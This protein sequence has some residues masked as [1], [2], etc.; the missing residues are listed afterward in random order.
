LKTTSNIIARPLDVS[1]PAT[2]TLNENSRM[3][4]D[5][6]Q[7]ELAEGLR[8]YDAGEYFAAHEAWETVWLV[9][10]EPE[11]IFLQGV[12][13][14]TAALHHYQRNNLVGTARLLQAALRRLDPCPPS[15]GGIAVALLRDDIRG[16]LQKLA[17]NYP[18]LQLTPPRIQPLSL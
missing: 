14:V 13:Q 15:F 11:K 17:A 8:R 12:I 18:T 16:C 5:W 4:L 1:S 7:G 6:T 10:S 2:L 9:S 3:A